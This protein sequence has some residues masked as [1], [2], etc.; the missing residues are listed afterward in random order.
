MLWLLSAL[1]TIVLMLK[2][3]VTYIAVALTVLVAAG[4]E[5]SRLPIATRWIA[6]RQS[7]LRRAWALSLGVEVVLAAVYAWAEQRTDTLILDLL[8]VALM[9]GVVVWLNLRRGTKEAT[10]PAPEPVRETPP[11]PRPRYDESYDDDEPLPDRRSRRRRRV[12]RE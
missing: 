11:A 6:E 3:A 5:L 8:G 12:P 10:A 9:I 2:N 1:G 7:V 4:N